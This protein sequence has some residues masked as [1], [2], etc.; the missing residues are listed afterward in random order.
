MNNRLTPTRDLGR[1]ATRMA[2]NRPD[3]EWLHKTLVRA[4]LLFCPTPQYRD[5][6]GFDTWLAGRKDAVAYYPYWEDRQFHC[7][8]LTDKDDML[9]GYDAV[10]LARFQLGF[11]LYPPDPVYDPFPFRLYSRVMT[12]AGTAGYVCETDPLT[13]DWY[14]W[15]P[16]RPESESEDRPCYTVTADGACSCRYY[17]SG[18]PWL[19]KRR[20]TEEIVYEGDVP[21]EG[22]S[23]LECRRE[24]DH[25]LNFLDYT[26]LVVTEG[27]PHGR[28]CKHVLARS[29]V[30]R[31]HDGRK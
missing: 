3:V 11:S 13:G 7:V 31:R 4:L 9:V 12:I 22:P 25:P 24:P 2:W 14:I 16:D 18:Y 17:R 10:E 8:Y 30:E 21:G 27:A 6:T 15:K 28:L 1:I 19:V 23:Y 29:F 26:E 20:G 5:R